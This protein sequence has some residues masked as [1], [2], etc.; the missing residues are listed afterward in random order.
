MPGLY[1]PVR[2]GAIEAP[3]RIL[4]APLTRGRATVPGFIP[5]DVMRL[6]YEQRAGAGLI[7]SEATGISQ[8]GL[9]WPAAPGIWWKP[10]DVRGIASACSNFRP[11][12]HFPKNWSEKRP[13]TPATCLWWK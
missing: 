10:A 12:G 4:M 2:L 8:E 7:I 3:N 9:G 5:N 13:S 11:S 1:D 6:Y